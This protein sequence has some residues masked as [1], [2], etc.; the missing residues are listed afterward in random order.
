MTPLAALLALGV[1][2]V[3]AWWMHGW[4]S[5]QRARSRLLG[6]AG[7]DPGAAQ[8]AGDAA[9]V[10]RGAGRA[11]P[12]PAVALV[13]GGAGIVAAATMIGPIAVGLAGVAAVAASIVVR[14]RRR[15]EVVAGRRAQLPQALERLAAA[16][17]SGSSLPV[18]LGEAGRATPDPLGAELETVARGAAQG[19]PIAGV[20]DDWTRDHRDPG[21]RLAATALVLATVV[22][23]AP[24]RAVDG[25]AS[26]LRERL[27]LAAE[28]RALASQART[29]AVVLSLA[30]L[31][32]AVLLAMTDAAAARF[33]L[34][35]TAGWVCLA[36]GLGLNA[37]GAWWMARLTRGADP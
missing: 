33:L 17:R 5:S 14:C 7:D 32:F 6:G 18:A 35:T 26:T 29:S 3:T 23:A 9:G 22:G 16:L 2:A 31:A 37:L 24:A 11:P 8:R 27:E 30:P 20:L 34:R 25:V 15:T 4:W 36:A 12:V 21:T 1:P 10:A 28:R 13:A 19:Q